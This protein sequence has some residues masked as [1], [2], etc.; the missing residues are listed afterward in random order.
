MIAVRVPS[1]I[2]SEQAVAA[3]QDFVA[4]N[5]GNL[6]NVAQ[7]SRIVSGLRSA[8]VIPLTLTSPGYGIV[9]VVGTLMVD[10]ELGYIMGWTPIEEIRANAEQITRQY[11]AELEAAFVPLQANHTQQGAQVQSDHSPAMNGRG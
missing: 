7:P 11:Q 5:L 1:H 8:W 2:A 9:G 10:E 3:A 4:D 6:V